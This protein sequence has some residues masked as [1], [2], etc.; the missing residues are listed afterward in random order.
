[1]NEKK[2]DTVVKKTRTSENIFKVQDGAIVYLAVYNGYGIARISGGYH[3]IE[4]TGKPFEYIGTIGARTR[5][6]RLG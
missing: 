6:F 3:S 4:P 1:M 2:S 5:R